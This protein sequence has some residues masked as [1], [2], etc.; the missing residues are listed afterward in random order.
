VF[1]LKCRPS[2]SEKGAIS[3]AKIASPDPKEIAQV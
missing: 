1:V 2:D 3:A